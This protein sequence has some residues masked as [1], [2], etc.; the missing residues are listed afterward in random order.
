MKKAIQDYGV[1]NIAGF[2]IGNEYMLNTVKDDALTSAAI[3]LKAS[4]FLLD[5]HADFKSMLTSLNL[6]KNIPV[7][8]AD[9]GAYF[10]PQ[11]MAGVDYAM[12]NIHPWFAQT[13]IDKATAWTVDSYNEYNQVRPIPC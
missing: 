8:V 11:L 6:P 7:G 3:G 5:K 13:T 10:N 9:A 1:D 12:E 2:T 4:Q